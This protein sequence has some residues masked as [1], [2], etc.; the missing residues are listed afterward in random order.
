MPR[1]T[2]V[3]ACVQGRSQYQQLRE[4]QRGSSGTVYLAADVTSGKQVAMK[5]LPRSKV[6]LGTAREIAC[7][8]Q[9]LMHPHI[10]Q[11]RES[12]LTRDSLAV[13][14]EFASGGDLRSASL[15]LH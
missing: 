13:V 5:L 1:P 9:C 3:A 6:D 2:A 14:M 12:F 15:P 8:R 10:V 7:Q 4:L 11:F